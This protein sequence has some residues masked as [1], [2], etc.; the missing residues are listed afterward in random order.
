MKIDSAAV[1]GLSF[2]RGG[3]SLWGHSRSSRQPADSRSVM[4]F[5][6]Q[7]NKNGKRVIQRWGTGEPVD[8][9]TQ[10]ARKQKSAA[11]IVSLLIIQQRDSLSDDPGK[12]AQII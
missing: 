10:A 7:R 2:S 9:A 3:G 11:Q 4:G 12:K 5:P 6:I 8:N 1:C